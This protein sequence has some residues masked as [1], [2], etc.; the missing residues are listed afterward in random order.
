MTGEHD[1]K[2]Y[3]DDSLFVEDWSDPARRERYQYWAREQYEFYKAAREWAFKANVDYGKWLVASGLLVHG[4]GLYALNAL[5][6]ASDQPYIHLALIEGA[7]WHVAGI[8]FVLIAGLMAWFN[9]QA[10]ASIYDDWANP[11]MVYKTDEIPKQLPERDAVGATRLAS[12]LFGAL[13]FWAL[14]ASAATV[15][16]ALE[17]SVAT[18]PPNGSQRDAAISA[19]EAEVGKLTN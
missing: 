5:R 2:R 11:L 3:D 12:I 9:F 6:D 15:L 8:V 7:K 16:P 10:A 18:N 4:A 17:K 19:V 1:Q 13:A 14:I